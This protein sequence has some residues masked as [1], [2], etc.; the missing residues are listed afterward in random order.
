MRI[1]ILM[2]RNL[3]FLDFHILYPL[4]AFARQCRERDIA[5]KFVFRL[6]DAALDGC[7]VVIPFDGW[8]RRLLPPAERSAEDEIA[9]MDRLRQ[10]VPAVFWFDNSD[11]SGDVRTG[12]VSHVDRYLKPQILRELDRYNTLTV[13]GVI[14]R[15]Y[16]HHTRG[17]ADD[18]RKWRGPM[19]EADLPRL[20]AAW[21][22]GLGNLSV[23]RQNRFLRKARVH[24]WTYLGG[25][26]LPEAYHL[27][28]VEPDLAARPLDVSYRAN[29][30]SGKPTVHFHRA[31]AQRRLAA[32]AA[33]TSYQ[34]RLGGGVR[35]AEYF[36]EMSQCKVVVSPFGLGELCYRDFESFEAGAVLL[37]PDMSH[38]DT[39]P[40]YFEPGVTYV[41]YAWDYSNFEEKL[42]DILEHP[43]RYE[44]IARAGQQRYLDSQSPAGG[45]RFAD[46]L[47]A[48]MAL[49]ERQGSPPA[50]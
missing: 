14:F 16:Y 38:L 22:L 13:T 34:V 24:Y 29:L 35:P 1:A 25:R 4:R 27:Q 43:A 42:V 44:A 46:R 36:A 6:N 31:E 33:R 37:K 45:E 15:D 17:I 40:D 26:G 18:T 9:L 2:N 30:W 8:F 23:T 12:L 5:V 21:N 39:W 50:S 19:D 3:S 47:L 49:P 7:D 48:L 11:S 32:L 20:K 28:P 10:L 41:P